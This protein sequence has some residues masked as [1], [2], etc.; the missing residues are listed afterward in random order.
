[1]VSTR[2]LIALLIAL[3]IAG[4]LTVPLAAADAPRT[5]NSLFTPEGRKAAGRTGTYSKDPHVWVYTRAFAER[6]G[7]PEQW[8]DEGLQGAEALAYRVDWDYYGVK[9][10]YFGE[11]ETCR[12]AAACTLDM[13]LPDSADLPWNTQ[14]SNL[15][16]IHG[17]KTIALSA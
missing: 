9:C 17:R 13:Y 14:T 3:L 7:M 5:Y 8:I 15:I 16:R 2:R 10:G 1:M 6:F 4:V 11:L 12:P